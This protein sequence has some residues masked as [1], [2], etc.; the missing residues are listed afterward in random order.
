MSKKKS[1]DNYPLDL[2]GQMIYV[3]S[4]VVVPTI[5]K[6]LNTEQGQLSTD[7]YTHKTKLCLGFVTKLTQKRGVD[8]QVFTGEVDASNEFVSNIVRFT[9]PINEICIIDVSTLKLRDQ[10]HEAVR[11]AAAMARNDE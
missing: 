11:F 3:G 1:G 5:T 2:K 6:K 4:I 10:L 8:I 7:P 9:E